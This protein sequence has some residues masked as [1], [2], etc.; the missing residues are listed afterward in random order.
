M[1]VVVEVPPLVA[2]PEVVV[3]GLHGIGED[4][5]VRRHDLVH[6]PERVEG[7]ELMI[8]GRPALDVGALV[9]EQA[10]R[11][12]QALAAD[13]DHAPR[14][15]GRQEVDGGVGIDLAKRPGDRDVALDVTE[16]D[17]AREPE[18]LA[19]ASAPAGRRRVPLGG[20]RNR[21]RSDGLAA[22]E[23]AYEPVHLRGLASRQVVTAALERHEPR[24][25]DGIGELL[26]VAVG[27]DLVLRAVE[28]EHGGGEPR[29]QIVD[30]ILL[31]LAQRLDEDI[32]RRLAGPRDAVLDAFERVRLGM[33]LLEEPRPPAVEVVPEDGD[34]LF[35][36]RLGE[37][38]RVL[39]ADEDQVRDALGMIDRVADC[40]HARARERDERERRPHRG[41]E[42]GAEIL[43]M[44]DEVV[45]GQR[46]IRAAVASR[47]HGR[48]AK[49]SRQV[50]DLVLPHAAIDGRL[51]RRTEEDVAAAGAGRLVEDPRARSLHVH[52]RLPA[53]RARS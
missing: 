45:A 38:L 28:D 34:D 36:E 48:H 13:L 49:V 24:T 12:M 20:R 29:Q 39:G 30:V 16:T 53:R 31:D 2:D 27:H 52:Q 9:E 46:P 17:R 32:R 40:E 11:R 14:G 26:A 51:A 37:R 8:G 33:D 18:D 42:H 35:V 1:Q 19:P 7:V 43:V 50:R 21:G 4:H 23:V 22:H 44:R 15:I 41:V 6:V 3:T 5:E 10:R 25:G 47:V